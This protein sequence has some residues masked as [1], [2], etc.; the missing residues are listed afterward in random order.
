MA[1]INE[2]CCLVFFVILLITSCKNNN[3]IKSQIH[4]DGSTKEMVLEL[5]SIAMDKSNINL[6]H[7]NRL[8][9][10]AIDEKIKTIKDPGQYISLSFKSSVEW[11]NAGEY[12]FAIDK[13]NAIFPFI[14]IPIEKKDNMLFGMAEKMHGKFFRNYYIPKILHGK[15]N[16]CITSHI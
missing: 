12:T 14:E 7:L 10:M 2:K 11:L 16:G 3:E 15:Q 13:L 5:K 4:L 9:A 8:R 6:W 1:F